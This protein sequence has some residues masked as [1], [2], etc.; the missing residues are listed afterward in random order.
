[1]VERFTKTF[2]R[3]RRGHSHTTRASAEKCER[4]TQTAA[5]K[6]AAKRERQEQRKAVWA[7]KEAVRIEKFRARGKIVESGPFAGLT[8][9]AA[10]LLEGE[11]I[12]GPEDAWNR[13]RSELLRS[14]GMG[15]MTLYEVEQ[16]ITQKHLGARWF[17][18]LSERAIMALKYQGLTSQEAVIKAQPDDWVPSAWWKREPV[19]DEITEWLR[20]KDEWL[21]E[22]V[23]GK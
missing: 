22:N 9:R 14:P 11:G 19:I 8:E 13:T 2:W 3:C 21:V 6:V 18:G 20:T 1:M 15:R 16:W 5:E 10:K 4:T 17:D 12:V 7:A 23:T